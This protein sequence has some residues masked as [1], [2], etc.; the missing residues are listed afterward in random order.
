MTT[1]FVLIVLMSQL[2]ALAHPCLRHEKTVAIAGF[3]QRDQKDATFQKGEEFFLKIW[4]QIHRGR[5]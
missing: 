2:A 3:I 4:E 5:Q 1:L